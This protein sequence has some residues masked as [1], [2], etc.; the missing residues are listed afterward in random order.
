MLSNVNVMGY[1]ANQLILALATAIG[2]YG[3]FPTAPALFRQVASNEI[4]Q[5]ALV[6]VLVWQ[7]GAGQDHKLALLI[8][9]AMYAANK[10]LALA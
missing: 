5:W 2:A 10:A 9:A 8:T 4:A 7:G 1:T 6:F 3:G